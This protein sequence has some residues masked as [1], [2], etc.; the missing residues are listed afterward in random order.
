VRR[1][2]DALNAP[3]ERRE[4]AEKEGADDFPV[5]V[6]AQPPRGSR[7]VVTSERGRRRIVIPPGGWNY[8]VF[9]VA[10]FG[11][12][13]GGFGGLAALVGAGIVTGVRVNGEMPNGSVW[14]LAAIGTLFFLI[15]MVISLG[16]LVGSRTREVVEDGVDRVVVGF[17]AA[18]MSWGKKSLLKR[19]IEGVDLSASP[20]ATWS[21]VSAKLE[22]RE[23]PPPGVAKDVRI[24]TDAKVLRIGRSL[25]EGDQIWLRDTLD[26]MARGS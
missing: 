22:K 23:G 7:I 13:F 2:F 25:P 16:V 20:N 3:L 21:A 14:F 18:G 8:G 15:G 4:D 5:R 6:S 9:L 1:A 24:R 26:T 19:E 10:A 12:M 11:A 17:S